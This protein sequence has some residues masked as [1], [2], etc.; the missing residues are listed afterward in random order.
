MATFELG[1]GVAAVN[2]LLIPPGYCGFIA[3]TKVGQALELN[4]SAAYTGITVY[5]IEALKYHPTEMAFY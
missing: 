2:S 4:S 5:A 3:A 1:L